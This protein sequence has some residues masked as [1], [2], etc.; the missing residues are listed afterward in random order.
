MCLNYSNFFF[1]L[2]GRKFGAPSS[3]SSEPSKAPA[4]TNAFA[5]TKLVA[6]NN[7][8]AVQ[9]NSGTTAPPSFSFGAAPTT[10]PKL[11]LFGQSSSQKRTT[12]TTTTLRSTMPQ[13]CQETKNIENALVAFIATPEGDA[14]Y[15]DLFPNDNGPRLYIEYVR[16]A[17]RH[18]NEEA[19]HVEADISVSDD[20]DDS[21]VETG[22][23]LPEE[24]GGLGEDVTDLLSVSDGDEDGDDKDVNTVDVQ[25]ENAP[26]KTWKGNNFGTTNADMA[27]QIEAIEE[28]TLT[29]PKDTKEIKP[30]VPSTSVKKEFV[31]NPE[32]NPSNKVENGEIVVDVPPSCGGDGDEVPG[33]VDVNKKNEEEASSKER[34]KEDVAKLK[35]NAAMVGHMLLALA[36]AFSISPWTVVFL[37]IFRLAVSLQSRRA[38]EAAYTPIL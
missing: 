24:G 17:K 36:M 11:F 16:T 3:S 20:D 31:D 2:F 14:F 35:D 8:A 19:N 26:S 6:N 37:Y 29:L 18:L 25:G 9:L 21:D 27:T 38:C 15:R 32:V 28:A 12:T 34:E 10:E 4:V 30:T 22:P 5:S 33:D 13:T 7:A 1:S 23:Y